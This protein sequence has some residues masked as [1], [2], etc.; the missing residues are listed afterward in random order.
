[1]S[2]GSVSPNSNIPFV[3]RRRGPTWWSSIVMEAIEASANSDNSWDAEGR[4][5]MTTLHGIHGIIHDG[6]KQQQYTASLQITPLTSGERLG[7]SL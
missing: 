2:S 7:W 1:V 6:R 3:L 5:I 4:R